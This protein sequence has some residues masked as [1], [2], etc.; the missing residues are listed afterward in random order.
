M[1]LIASNV[2][3]SNK[4]NIFD[5]NYMI[6][7]LSMYVPKEEV[8]STA[9]YCN[10][11]EI[12]KKKTGLYGADAYVG[13]TEHGFYFVKVF[14]PEHFYLEIPFS[15]I[16]YCTR[17]KGILGQITC[18]LSLKNGNTIKILIAKRA[19]ISLKG[20]KMSHHTENRDKLLQY[21]DN[22]CRNV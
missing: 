12:N 7:Q 20:S 6:K 1:I 4:I 17:K 16:L 15:E 21:L 5:E 9:L 8:I 19:G 3:E 2:N 18:F 13:I 14:E 10:L 22:Y 11:L